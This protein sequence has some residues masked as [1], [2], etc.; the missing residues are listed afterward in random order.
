MD[1]SCQG[2]QEIASRLGKPAVTSS[3]L[4][5]LE[6]VYP[7]EEDTCFIAPRVKQTALILTSARGRAG[8]VK[9]GTFELVA[10]CCRGG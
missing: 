4:K 3:R 2:A 1:S 10:A 9:R 5:T 8:R 6:D 7:A